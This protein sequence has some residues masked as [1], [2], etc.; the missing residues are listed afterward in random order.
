MT[1]LG[2]RAIPP[3][4][5][6]LTR[7]ALVLLSI[8]VSATCALAQDSG[9]LAIRGDVLKPGRW[10]P[11]DVRRQFADQIQPVKFS[12]GEGKEPHVGTGVPLL[13]LLQ[14]AAPRVEKVPKHHDMTF[15]VIIEARDGYRAFFSLAEL[16]P[17]V[18]HAQ[19]LLI[20]EMDGKPL[21]D[22]EAPFRLIVSSDKERDRW[23]YGI[24]SVTL[25]DGAKLA[26]QLESGR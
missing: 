11:E 13:S 26:N 2:A 5:N 24:S 19:A 23:I 4:M 20:W 17:N 14:A 16:L 6:T 22:K 7:S 3:G 25:V 12:T 1:T 9:S 21:A 8:C 15:L 18:G 10:S